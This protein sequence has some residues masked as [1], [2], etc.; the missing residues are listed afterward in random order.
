MALRRVFVESI[1]GARARVRG[2]RAH[3]LRRVVRLRVGELVEISD[4]ERLFLA[5][6]GRSTAEEVE[7]EIR[8]SIA[9]PASAPRI[10]L[11]MAVIK[12]A[13]LE[14][15]IEKA[16]ELGVSS[17]LPVVAARCEARLIQ[18]AGKRR[19]RWQRIAEEAAQQ[20][21]RL[22]PPSIEPPMPLMAAL[23]KHD[24]QLAIILDTD[25]PP[26]RKAVAEFQMKTQ[27]TQLNS[28]VLLVGPEGGWTDA[29]REAAHGAGYQPASLGNLILRSET[30]AVTALGVLTHLLE[31]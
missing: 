14:W 18:A 5:A 20:S 16:T 8:E 26:L 9:P 6:V 25:C 27:P 15:V 7:F 30:A 28:A 10:V 21:R 2:P 23:P 24:T 12:F 29:E 22:A 13:R 1:R 19:E 3:H 4:H 31:A 17:I 11:M